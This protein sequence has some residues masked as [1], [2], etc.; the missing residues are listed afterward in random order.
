[1]AQYYNLLYLGNLR[2]KKKRTSLFPLSLAIHYGIWIDVA[3][4]RASGVVKLY[5]TVVLKLPEIGNRGFGGAAK[6]RQTTLPL[7]ARICA[8]HTDG[9]CRWPRATVP[10]VIEAVDE[11]TTKLS[12]RFVDGRMS[13]CPKRELTH[14]QHAKQHINLT[15]I[16][17][18][19]LNTKRKALLS[20]RRDSQE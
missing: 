1:M 15:S 18:L 6:H 5:R 13:R 7:C 3:T 8:S 20:R 10:T 12:E 4:L 19:R 14:V 16:G 17:K 9:P 11:Q 2:S